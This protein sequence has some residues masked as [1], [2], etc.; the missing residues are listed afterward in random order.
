MSRNFD[1]LICTD[2]GIMSV[3][4]MTINILLLYTLVSKFV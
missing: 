3:V 1:M 2:E 4:K